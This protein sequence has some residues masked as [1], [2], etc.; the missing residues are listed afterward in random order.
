MAADGG[1]VTLDP[2][3]AR[4]IITALGEAIVALVNNQMNM[5]SLS[6]T[7]ILKLPEGKRALPVSVILSV[8]EWADA[9]ADVGQR[10]LKIVAATPPDP[11][12]GSN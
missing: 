4:G 10:L 8:G 6:D 12:V 3:F 7:V 11:P 9:T 5:I 1:F 2:N